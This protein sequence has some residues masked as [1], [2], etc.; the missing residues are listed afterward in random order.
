M[1]DSVVETLTEGIKN[2]K[3]SEEEREGKRIKDICNERR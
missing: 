2:S 3:L 1:R